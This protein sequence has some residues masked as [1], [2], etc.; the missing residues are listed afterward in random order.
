MLMQRYRIDKVGETFTLFEESTL[1]CSFTRETFRKTLENLDRSSKWIGYIV[2]LLNQQYPYE[3]KRPSVDSPER[4]GAGYLIDYM[5][6]KGYKVFR[7]L[8]ISDFEIACYLMSKGF[9]VV[10]PDQEDIKNATLSC[11]KDKSVEHR[12][13]HT[14]DL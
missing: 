4:Y 13:R 1:V 8:P 3:A 14:S 12:N 6:S 9:D 5:Q 2:R 11:Q 7:P 10:S